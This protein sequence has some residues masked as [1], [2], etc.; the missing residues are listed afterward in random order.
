MEK[1][2]GPV[3]VMCDLTDTLKNLT[4]I[5]S[6]LV[7]EWLGF[8]AFTARAQVQSLGWEGPLEEGM[9]THP[10]ILAWRIPTHRGAWG[11]K[12]SDMTE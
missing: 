10:S 12:E 7:A 4:H 2:M 8:Q 9:A 1:Q 11:R 5:G 6:S 3:G